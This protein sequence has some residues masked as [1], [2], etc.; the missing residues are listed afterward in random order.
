MNDRLNQNEDMEVLVTSYLLGELSDSDAQKVKIALENDPELE[1]IAKEIETAIGVIRQATST[2]SAKHDSDLD[3]PKKLSEH[4]RKDL[5]ASFKGDL[6]GARQDKKIRNLPWFVPMG[7]AASLILLLSA[8]SF[9]LQ[10]K[11]PM[12]DAV[13]A[14]ERMIVLSDKERYDTT[15][16][17]SNSMIPK[18]EKTSRRRLSNN[19]RVKTAAS[20]EESHN[21]FISEGL[22]AEDIPEP[23]VEPPASVSFGLWPDANRPQKAAE[24]RETS[25][26]ESSNEELSK[27]QSGMSY[28]LNGP[29]E[30]AGSFG[31]EL[32]KS[33]PTVVENFVS[34]GVITNEKTSAQLGS[35]G[36]AEDKSSDLSLSSKVSAAQPEQ[37]STDKFRSLPAVRSL[38]DTMKS[39]ENFKAA[40]SPSSSV[41]VQ[42]GTSTIDFLAVEPE[43]EEKL[44]ALYEQRGPD[45]WNY[46]P[47]NDE[48][49]LPEAEIT[50]TPALNRLF[51]S[52]QKDVELY[53]MD[54][55]DG[56][57]GGVTGF[58]VDT[59]PSES[60]RAEFG[61]AVIENQPEQEN[62]THFI[63]ESSEPVV[64]FGDAVD[65]QLS[66]NF[67]DDYGRA[68]AT[69]SGGM[70]GGGGGMLGLPFVAGTSEST[71]NFFDEVPNDGLGLGGAYDISHYSKG[72]QMDAISQGQ[73][74]AL[75]D[76][77]VEEPSPKTA[78]YIR[79]NP[80]SSK[81]VSDDS[82]LETQWGT[83]RFGINESLDADDHMA[84]GFQSQD[85]VSNGRGPQSVSRLS[86]GMQLSQAQ[87]PRVGAAPSAP[88]RGRGLGEQALGESID[89]KSVEFSNGNSPTL[90][91]SVMSRRSGRL[92]DVMNRFEESEVLKEVEQLSEVQEKQ[93]QAEAQIG[94]RF[95]VLKSDLKKLSE[96]EAR[97]ESISA[98]LS[99]G[100]RTQSAH[101]ALGRAALQDG[102]V[103][104]E[105]QNL[106]LTQPAAATNVEHRPEID[107]AEESTS[108]F[109]LNVSDVSFK[110]AKAA[111]NEGQLP[112]P[113]SI[114]SEQFLNA[115]DYRDPAPYSNQPVGFHSEQ[116]Q[117]PF[118][119]HRDVLRF[120]LQTSATGRAGDRP[121]HLTLLLDNSGSMERADR[122]RILHQALQVLS[123]Q[124]TA[125]DKISVVSFARTARLWVDGVPGGAPMPLLEKV[126]LLTPQGGTNIEEALKAA[127]EV[128]S[129]HYIKDGINRVVLLTD[130]AAN[131][132]SIDPEVLKQKV[133]D[134]RRRGIAFDCFGIG[135]DGLNDPLLEVLSRNGDGRYGFLNDPSEAS[136]EFA[137]QLAGALNVAASDVKVQVEFNPDRVNRWRQVGYAKHQLKKEQFRDNTVDAAEI[138]A[139]ESGNALYVIEPIEDGRGPIGQVRV[140][141]RV[142]HTSEYHEK[143]WTVPYRA[144]IPEIKESS[145]AMKLAI[146]SGFFA[147]WLNG[148][149]HAGGVSLADL[150]D[151]YQ[152]VPE[153]FGEDPRPYQ[154]EQMIELARDI[155][156]F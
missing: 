63:A 66:D 103:S 79:V 113:E 137:D 56:A 16:L 68:G 3:A 45:R 10:V 131:L 98:E 31:A 128:A 80:T 6:S 104:V 37:I 87:Q 20:P 83:V 41:R 90:G 96:V 13:G 129:N 34:G 127:Y 75:Q 86:R 130:G 49:A 88:A 100:A 82:G 138:A 121:M 144:S 60:P 32:R 91:K 42:R 67:S 152:G 22:V 81:P 44:E 136:R 108:T 112:N 65:K 43:M 140:R 5:F 114:R 52:K 53:A 76:T 17:F 23:T 73:G 123:Q 27:K 150:Q 105:K 77:A 12:Q 46:T 11:S 4:R 8:Y 115:F 153:A 62:V 25:W 61:G 72:L 95:Q 155:S 71:E 40:K 119:H 28:R 120:A 48:Y 59:R 14:A 124:L 102:D 111:L 116:S 117:H 74:I 134:E 15:E 64:Q 139:T 85:E 57:L 38:E 94:Q 84:F 51:K 7:I 18:V 147:E 69:Y 151:I 143:E 101:M 55:P 93:I 106:T 70:G 110:L 118:A 148:N 54:A 142:P 154:L 21:Y 89:A 29:Q 146:T 141:Y 50:R 156:G 125:Q 99:A 149:P 35:L 47:A 33:A 39:V 126:N 2:D 145:P 58:D 92:G 78:A 24:D 133:I 30:P 26:F 36:L 97:G 135:W 122:R 1:A 132:G 9:L 109:S 19:S 107:T